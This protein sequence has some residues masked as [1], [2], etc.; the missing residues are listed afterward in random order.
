[1]K[2]DRPPNGSNNYGWCIGNLRSA[3]DWAM[4]PEEGTRNWA[5]RSTADAVTL[6][7]QLSL[8]QGTAA[9]GENMR[10]KDWAMRPHRAP[11][12]R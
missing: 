5:S 1:M 10:W 12:A 7:S 11:R 3:L 9:A 2:P 6:W 4:Q 8:F